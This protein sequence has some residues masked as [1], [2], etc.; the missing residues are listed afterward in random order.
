VFFGGILLSLLEVFL[1][2]L[3]LT[4]EIKSIYF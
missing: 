1:H 2:A 3:F 4:N